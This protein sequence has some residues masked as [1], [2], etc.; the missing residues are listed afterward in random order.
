LEE[1]WAKHNAGNIILDQL[2]STDLDGLAKVLRRAVSTGQF[3]EVFGPSGYVWHRGEATF[4]N[5]QS[6]FL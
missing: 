6:E 2:A 1:Q 4:E 5:W 3:T